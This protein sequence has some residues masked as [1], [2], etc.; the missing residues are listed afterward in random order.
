MTLS[1]RKVISIYFRTW[2]I[3]DLIAAIPWVFILPVD[4]YSLIWRIAVVLVSLRVVRI[5]DML[6]RLG[7]TFLISS[8]VNSLLTFVILVLLVSHWFCCLFAVLAFG[9]DG[10]ERPNL[11]VESTITEAYITAFYWSTMT[12]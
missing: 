5:L 9:F 12:M 10:Q 1:R 3:V 4:Q 6:N 7:Q 8:A 11:L 2:F